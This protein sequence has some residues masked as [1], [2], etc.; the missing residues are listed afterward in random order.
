MIGQAQKRLQSTGCGQKVKLIAGGVDQLDNWP[1]SF[2]RVY[3]LNVIQFIADKPG[4]FARVFKT[5]DRGGRCFTTYQPRLDFD[6]PDGALRMANTISGIMKDTG[7][8]NITR[9]GIDAGQ[10]PAICV[11]AEKPLV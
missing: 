6:D 10:A 4:F 7:F 11:W 3:S 5:L 9:S 2:D 1:G 8:R